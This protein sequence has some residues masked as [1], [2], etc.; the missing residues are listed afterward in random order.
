MSRIRTNPLW[1]ILTYQL[2]QICCWKLR[3]RGLRWGQNLASHWNGWLPLQTVRYCAA[4]DDDDDDDDD[5][6][7]LMMTMT[8]EIIITIE[9]T[10]LVNQLFARYLRGDF[11]DR[12]SIVL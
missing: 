3:F 10:M 5:D 1:T 4:C 9:Y 6:D 2:C 7:E 12:E 8:T 11:D